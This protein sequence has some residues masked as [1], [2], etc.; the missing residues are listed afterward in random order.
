MKGLKRRTEKDYTMYGAKIYNHK[1]QKIGLLILTWVNVYADS[2]VD[3]ATW[4]NLK[5]DKYNI[6]M[7]SITPVEE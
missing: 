7:G 4:V 2:N 5:G 1:R 3:F 6:K